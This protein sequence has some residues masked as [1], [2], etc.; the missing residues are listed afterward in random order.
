MKVTKEN[1]RRLLVLL[2]S[3]IQELVEMTNA[4]AE[5]NQTLKYDIYFFPLIYFSPDI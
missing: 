1:T 2:S 4:V 5:L 3:N